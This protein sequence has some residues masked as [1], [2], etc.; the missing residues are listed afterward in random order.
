MLHPDWLLGIAAAWFGYGALHSWLASDRVKALVARR[1]PAF[2]PAYRLAYNGL[3]LILLFPPLWLTWTYPGP[4]LW[5]VPAWISWPALGIVAAGLLWSL[6]WYDGMD[7]TGLRQWRSRHTATGWRDRLVLSPL[8]R[9][10]RHPWYSLGLLYLWTR[11]MNAGWLVGVLAITVYLY[12]GSRAEERKLVATFGESYRRYRNR[13]PGLVPRPWRT[14]RR[15]EAA[16]LLA[17][18]TTVQTDKTSSS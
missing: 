17:L 5:P 14:I 18:S 15:D 1:W 2:V 12:L 13:V 6:R 16:S 11:E 7:F 10:V 9:Y 4:P 8:H 3:A